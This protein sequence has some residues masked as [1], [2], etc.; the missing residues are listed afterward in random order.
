[1]V[2][3]TTMVA[4]VVFTLLYLTGRGILY[5]AQRL[6]IRWL[7]S[8]FFAG[9]EDG[10]KK[11]AE[12]RAREMVDNAVESAVGVA[13]GEMEQRIQEVVSEAHQRAEAAD[14]RAEAAEQS[15]ARSATQAEKAAKARDT[16]R[17]G[18]RRFMRSKGLAEHEIEA[19]FRQMP[20]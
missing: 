17:E 15:A 9:I 8:T 20:S 6:E 7:M 5:L 14:R 16:D 2:I 4:P 18:F 12:R 3:R 10:I 11:A 13:L 19:Y 1:M